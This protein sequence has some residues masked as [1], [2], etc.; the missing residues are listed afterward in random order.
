MRIPSEVI[1]VVNI[2]STNSAKLF[3]PRDLEALDFLASNT[4]ELLRQTESAAS[5]AELRSHLN[6][7]ERLAFAGELTA[8]I[9]HEI[10]NPL[11]FMGA[12]LSALKEYIESIV[13]V[14]QQLKELEGKGLIPATLIDALKN[15]EIDS[16][17]DDAIPLI[18]ECKDGIDRCMGIIRDLK[19]MVK[20]E[21]SAEFTKVK[22]G[23]TVDQAL[24]LS[25]EKIAQRAS[26][27]KEIQPDLMA[28]GNEIQ[29]VQ[30]L[31]NLLNNAADAIA[32]RQKSGPNT[33]KGEIA[34]KVL[35]EGDSIVFSVTDDGCGMSEAVRARIF[36]PLFTTK[37]R[38]VGTGLGL[39]IVKRIV[40]SHSGSIDVESVEGKGTT[41]RVRL[42]AYTEVKEPAKNF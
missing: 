26:I 14:C 5:Q 27:K 38:D 21:P 40:T 17:V 28:L 29:V 30:I 3:S 41:M 25:R 6:G 31:V 36:E 33:N 42:P 20:S 13:P 18:I 11:A 22:V 35:Q 34:L 37:S 16:I 4:A 10:K 19:A 15:S 39:G 32:D 8:G 23:V 2:S 9:A 12:N 7:M 1:G 24:K